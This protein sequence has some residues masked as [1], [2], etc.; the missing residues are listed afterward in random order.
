VV[1]NR[2]LCCARQG[3][4][5][6]LRKL[7][8]EIEQHV[9]ATAFYTLQSQ[10]EAIAA[11]QEALLEI[12]KSIHKYSEEHEAFSLWV[13]RITGNSCLRVL[14]RRRE[15]HLLHDIPSSESIESYRHYNNK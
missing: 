7:L 13:Q 11:S 8:K 1:D 12:Y 10:P 15:R 3:N 14:S 6:C 4:H 2:L 9:Y 5:D